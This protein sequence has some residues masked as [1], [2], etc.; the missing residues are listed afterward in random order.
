M[1]L[2]KILGWFG[3]IFAFIINL[4]TGA[5]DQILNALSEF[6]A[7][8]EAKF[9]ALNNAL[10]IT[11]KELSSSVAQA[12]ASNI[13]AVNATAEKTAALLNEGFNKI[14]DQLNA[15]E[16]EDTLRKALESTLPDE[17]VKSMKW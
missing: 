7:N 3:Q 4:I 11:Q 12:S 10:A 17:V 15:G 9:E 8:A 14:T 13:E 1:K 2:S 16:D 5:K 6:R